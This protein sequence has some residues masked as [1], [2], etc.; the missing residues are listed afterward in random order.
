MTPFDQSKYREVTAI[1]KLSVKANRAGVHRTLNRKPKGK[2]WVQCRNSPASVMCRPDK[3][4]E[5]IRHFKKAYERFPDIVALNQ[6][7]LAYEMIGEF[8]AARQYFVL[9][10]EQAQREANEAYLKAAELG[11]E[12]IR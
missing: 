6:I 7:A 1:F 4:R 5:S 12:R 11:F 3:I 8:E 10:K 9:M 2:G